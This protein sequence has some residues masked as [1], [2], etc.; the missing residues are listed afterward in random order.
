MELDS[1]LKKMGQENKPTLSMKVVR[2]IVTK[3]EAEYKSAPTNTEI[4]SDV[5]LP[6]FKRAKPNVI[7]KG[8][9]FSGMSVNGKHR[10]IVVAK[11]MK[12]TA[13]CIALTT[14][15]DE[16]ALIPHNSRFMDKGFYCNQFCKVKLDFIT[17]MFTGVME[18]S[19]GLNKAIKLIIEQTLK[20]LQ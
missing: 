10:P 7:K 4:K 12:D 6:K 9:V 1:I 16:H 19:R 8:D 17:R 20:D 5:M 15:E 13:Y 14:T 3:V 2:E 11:V 18:D